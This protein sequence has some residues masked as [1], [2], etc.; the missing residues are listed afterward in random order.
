MEE[1]RPATDPA[2]PLQEA[3][4]LYKKAFDLRRAGKYD[5]ALPS[6]ERAL[7]IRERVLGPDHPDVAAAIDGLA[8]I[9]S[10]R[11]EYVKAEPLYKRALDIREKALGKDHPDNSERLNNLAILY[12]E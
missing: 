9:Y 10:Y 12:P 11:G 8:G 3:R 1:S 5:E 6:A 7:E 4:K 2:R